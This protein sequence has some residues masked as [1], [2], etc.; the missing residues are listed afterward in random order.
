M[1]AE[2]G[3]IIFAVTGS[4]SMLVFFCHTNRSISGGLR[5]PV[6]L[7]FKCSITFFTSCVNTK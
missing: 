4:A 1:D 2:C 3:C 6:N 5:P 7:D